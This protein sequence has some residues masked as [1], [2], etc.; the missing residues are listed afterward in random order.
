M[1]SRIVTIILMVG[2]LMVAVSLVSAGRKKEA[3][4]VFDR[5]LAVTPTDPAVLLNAALCNA[6]L[7]QWKK[8]DDF[9]R[10]ASERLPKSTTP[11]AIRGRIR[12]RQ[13]LHAEAVPFFRKALELA[14]EQA[15]A[16]YRL[17]KALLTGLSL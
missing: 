11:H 7:R 16:Q 9:A 8:A 13:E 10:R 14:P 15:T 3:A 4:K 17:G 1:R 2:I 12:V 6:D 5:I